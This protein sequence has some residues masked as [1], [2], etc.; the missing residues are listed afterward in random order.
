MADAKVSALDALTAV[1]ATDLLYVVD[2]PGGTPASK[3]ATAEN[4]LAVGWK[5]ISFVTLASNAASISLTDIPEAHMLY[6]EVH[7]RS[8]NGGS[9]YD[10]VATTFNADTNNNYRHSHNVSTLYAFLYGGVLA[11]SQVGNTSTSWLHCWISNI[12]SQRKHCL[13]RSAGSWYGTS[14]QL[15]ENIGHWVNATDAISSLTLT[16]VG[17]NNFV[18]GTRVYLFG[19]ML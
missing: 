13:A 8:S 16:L 14:P 3:K 15:I 11:G 12:A 18:A 17:G 10:W 6:L 2:D 9:A 5:R 19:M 7:G 4:V 1:E